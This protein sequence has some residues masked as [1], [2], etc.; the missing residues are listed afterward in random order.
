MMKNLRSRKYY[1]K[2]ITTR[3]NVQS[4]DQEQS[5]LSSTTNTNN[6]AHTLTHGKIISPSIWSY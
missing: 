4:H 2:G 5:N 1:N 3:D 6:S